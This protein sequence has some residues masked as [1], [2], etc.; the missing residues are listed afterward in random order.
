M[1]CTVEDLRKSCPDKVLIQATDDLNPNES[2]L[3]QVDI[4]E[5]QIALACGIIDGYLASVVTLPLGTVPVIV[6]KIAIDLS[7]HGLYERLDRV[8]KDDPMDIRKSNAMALLDKISKRLITIGPA[9]SDPGTPES[10][11]FLVSSGRQEFTDQRMAS[12]GGAFF[13]P[14]G[15]LF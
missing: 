5:E 9:D 4:V 3:I 13:A 11:A 14:P 15:G 6:K 12:L 2:G 7:L 1:Y 8:S 10:G